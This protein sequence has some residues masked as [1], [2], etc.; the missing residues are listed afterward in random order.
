MRE[1]G[2]TN[3]PT[4]VELK[5]FNKW[6]H[7]Y[8]FSLQIILEACKRTVL[9]HF[10]V[11]LSHRLLLYL[12]EA[13]YPRPFADPAQQVA[14]HAADGIAQRRHQDYRPRGVVQQQR[15]CQQRLRRERDN[16]CRQ[17]A[18]DE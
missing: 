12:Q 15:A 17:Q 2:L 11:R 13:F 3:A 16:R 14:R 9:L 10:L 6:Q 8:N 1:L 4:N 5:F 18:A 7:E